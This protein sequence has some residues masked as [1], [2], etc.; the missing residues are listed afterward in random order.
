MADESIYQL[1]PHIPDPLSKS[2]MHRSKFNPSAPP[3]YSTFPRKE[4]PAGARDGS[5]AILFAGR[6]GAIGRDVG[7]EIDPKRFMKAHSSKKDKLPEV[8]PFSRPLVAPPTMGVPARDD[9]PVMGLMTEKNFVHANAVDAMCSTAQK[10]G[11]V[12]PV[13]ATQ[14]ADFG[15]TPAYLDTVKSRIDQEKTM[16]ADARGAEAEYNASMKAQFV[17]EVDDSEKEELIAKLRQRWEE[18]HRQYHALPF[19]QDTAMQISRKEAM[20]RELKEIETALARLS[21]KVVVVYNDSQGRGV[22]QWS[23]SQAQQDA[24]SA[25]SRMVAEAIATKKSQH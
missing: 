12:A 25:A 16:L 24:Q 11:P 8:S 10:K 14:R 19:A 5:A 4:Q 17:R 18:K 6:S 7:P 15:K 3:S 2:K 22:A 23:K 13:L 20:E 9:K 21:K 1:I